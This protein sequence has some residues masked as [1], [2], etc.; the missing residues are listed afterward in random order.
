M[1][2]YILRV[3]PFLVIFLVVGFFL[4][5]HSSSKYSSEDKTKPVIGNV[6]NFVAAYE[7]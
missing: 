5:L 6:E 1:K 3:V 4:Q 7:Q 2:T